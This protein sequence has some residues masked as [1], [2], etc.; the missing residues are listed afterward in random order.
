MIDFVK[1]TEEL[2]NEKPKAKSTLAYKGS[3]DHME[4]HMKQDKEPVIIESPFDIE[5]A[6]SK[7]KADSVKELVKEAEAFVVETEPQAKQALNMAIQ[8]RT[9]RKSIEESRKQIVR[10]HLDFNAAINKVAKDFSTCLDGISNK[11]TV[12]VNKFKSELEKIYE[13]AEVK[14]EVKNIESEEAQ[15]YERESIYIEL[16]D[17]KKVPREYLSFD[18]AK[19]KKAVQMGVREI[20]GLKVEVK[21]V[22]SY[23]T[24]NT[25]VKK[26]ES[27]NI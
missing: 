27:K 22:T 21:K 10:P 5:I 14:V 3:I 19:A 17:I 11:L 20:P 9:M 4:K 13:K 1:M 8:A 16:Q 2:N 6:S 26:D 7:L 23:R 12:K 25:G 24:K 18:K 15:P